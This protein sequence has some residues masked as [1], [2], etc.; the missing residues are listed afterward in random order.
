MMPRRNA[1]HLHN[2]MFFFAYMVK[3]YGK[4]E[5][6]YI[7]IPD[8]HGRKFWREAVKGNEDKRIVF[9][10]D[11][12]DPYSFEGVTY[13]DAF[14]EFNDILAFKKQHP[15]NVTLL[16]GNH[17]L[18][19]LNPDI[20]LVR[21]DFERSEC[22][23]KVLSENIAL[24]NLVALEC[25]ADHE[26]LFSHAGIR[27]EWLEYNN[28]LFNPD[29]FKPEILNT[30]LHDE[31]RR[32]DLFITLADLTRY[33]GG[34][35]CA[36]S[37]VWADAREFIDANDELPGYFQIFGHTLH[38]DGPWRIDEHLWCVDCAKA[39]V[40]KPSDDESHIQLIPI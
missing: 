30:L 6:E 28:W 7:V 19:Y 29:D 9:L 24:F 37:V 8:V 5:K 32:E 38:R 26:V 33:R 17:D 22:Y 10:G 36:G 27:T 16:L 20:C 1:G 31:E 34:M 3:T 35:S 39:F 14:N 12:L 4:M 25:L 21:H 23:R 15:D 13:L 2:I 18:G 11:Y 40:L